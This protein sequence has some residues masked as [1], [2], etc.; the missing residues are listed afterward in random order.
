M[1]NVKAARRQAATVIWGLVATSFVMLLVVLYGGRE[2][3]GTP[4][5]GPYHA[6]FDLGAYV[7][8][9]LAAICAGAGLFLHFPGRAPFGE[10]SKAAVSKDAKNGGG[11]GVS[12]AG[13]VDS[14]DDLKD[15]YV[16]SLVL[17]LFGLLCYA[18]C[19]LCQSANVVIISNGYMITG[20]LVL[21]TR[22]AVLPCDTKHRWLD[23]RTA[24]VMGWVAVIGSLVAFVY[25]HTMFLSGRCVD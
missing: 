17:L 25:F 13:S 14:D 23:V 15:Y 18:F 19:H 1:D 5:E 10:A 9:V 11:A 22:V 8:P 21:R 20:A 6:F 4:V 2:P 16:A 7:F 3:L 24:K 12:R